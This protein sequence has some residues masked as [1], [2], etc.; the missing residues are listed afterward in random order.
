MQLNLS[1]EFA[2]TQLDF[3]Q[4]TL[5]QQNSGPV[6]A[7]L[8]PPSDRIELS[9]E[10][11]RPH[12]REHGIHKLHQGDRSHQ[13]T[14]LV[15]FIRDLLKQLT[16]AQVNALTPS[17]AQAAPQQAQPQAPPQQQTDSTSLDAQQSTLSVQ[18][19]S[20]SMD[21]TITTSDGVKFSFSMD[22][23]MLHASATNQAISFNQGPNG[24]SFDFAGTS[25]ELTS[26]S[27]Q[28]S[29]SAQLPDGTPASSD[30][31]GTFSLKNDLKE[32]GK[33]IKP[34]LQELFKA[35]GPA[36]GA[37]SADSQFHIAA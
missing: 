36:S 1:A 25:A 29:L 35:A 13:N 31:T 37:N 20:F 18:G 27:F 14:P 5:N 6:P 16:G 7:P 34:V 17:P 9:D 23:Q 33:A 30:G 24:S 22:L 19:T 10:A 4:L 11:R 26:T 8:P 12:G 3:T 28:F 15:N 21:G 32:L 2:S